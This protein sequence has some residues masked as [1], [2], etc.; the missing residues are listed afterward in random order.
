MNLV[1]RTKE[2]IVQEGLIKSGDIVL[3][4]VSGGM[5]SMALAH[6]LLALKGELDFELAIAN[7]NH[8]LRD[9]SAEEAEFVER[10]ALDNDLPFFL[11][12]ADIKVLAAGGNIQET[13]RR[14]RYA[15]LRSL[16]ARLP[17]DKIAVAHHSDDQAETVLLHLLRGSGLSGLGGMSPQNGT[18]IRP[19]LFTNR[20]QIEEFVLNQEIE[21]R[22][23]SSNASV[24]YLRNKIRLEL[25]P[26]LQEY[27]P[28]IAETLNATAD[29][30]REED[31]LLDDLAANALA[32]LW[33]TEDNTLEKEGFD[34]LPLA[35]QR[36]VLRKAYT[37]VMGEKRELTFEQVDA[38]LRLKDEQSTALP[39]G[40]VAYLRGNICFAA[41]KPALPEY[42]ES[43]PLL[44]DSAWHPIGELPWEYKACEA[45]V[46]QS[47][48][49][50]F[51]FF[52]ARDFLSKLCWRTRRE[53]DAVMSLG[54]NGKTKLKEIF[55]DNHIPI[56]ERNTWP[57]LVAEDE[58][59]WLAGLWRGQ[60]TTEQ[61]R[62]L[63]KV[64]SYDKII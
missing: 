7:F 15:F 64:R 55:I 14:E 58:I 45:A 9:E 60:E 8:Q 24:K 61:S 35:L 59:I 38:I 32:E 39:G 22:E 47:D 3:L 5:D 30:C 2:Y 34:A 49:D 25:L 26:Y 17:A 43:Y 1:K 50:A 4:A 51:S 53:G 42:S 46:Q 40:M 62:I 18:I 28:H 11:G 23:D 31:F 33:L 37:M 19:L 10:F 48:K 41:D 13:A 27:N 21:Y 52:A 20:K 54:K 44:L 63:I 29:I 6:I 16:A 56:Y 57:L 12:T 36:R